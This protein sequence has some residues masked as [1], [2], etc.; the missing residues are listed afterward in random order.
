MTE[1]RNKYYY[2]CNCDK[3]YNCL[4]GGKHSKFEINKVASKYQALVSWE[5]DV[6]IPKRVLIQY[7]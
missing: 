5:F 6:Y 7:D 2:F 4:N 1:K 3:Q